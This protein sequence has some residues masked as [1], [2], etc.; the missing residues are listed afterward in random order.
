MDSHKAATPRQI[1]RRLAEFTQDF[2]LRLAPERVLENAKLAILDCLGVSTV[3][4]GG[5]IGRALI[6]FARDNASRGPCTVWGTDISTTDRDAAL[7]NGTLAHGLDFDDRNHSSTYSLAA[8]LALAERHDLPGARVLEAFIVGREI[9]NCLDAL[10]S[11]R[12]SGVGPGARGWHSNGILGP[13]ATACAASKILGLD[14]DQTLAAIGLA[15][16]SCGALTRDGGTMAKPFRTG[17]AA[18]T[19]INSALLAQQGF[20]ADD[21]ILEGR[22][23]LLEALGPIPDSVMESLAANLGT[24]YNLEVPI[25][26]KKFAS[27]SASHS[28]L[29]AMLR[30]RQRHALRPDDVK[31]IECDLKPYPLVRARPARGVEGRFSL[32]FIL[33]MALFHGRIEPSD[34][35][36]ANVSDKVISRLMSITRHTPGSESL[37]VH[38]T[39]GRTLT[40]PMMKATDLTTWGEISDKFRTCVRSHLSEARTEEVITRVSHLDSD[41]PARALTMALR[42]SAEKASIMSE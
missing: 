17:Q 10:F 19:G 2:S 4:I 11:H 30:L 20:T 14:L 27:C 32:P 24:R 36:D 13:I 35:T 42:T 41:A 34:F 7:I 8:P 28:G 26:G 15:A 38:L 6:A 25:R 16:G 5:E 22:Y 33:A 3:A 9:R 37:V 31:A 21:T 29:E 23:G 18:A 40:E 39:D 1:T 12:G